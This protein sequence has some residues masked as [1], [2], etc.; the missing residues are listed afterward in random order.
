MRRTWRN[1]LGVVGKALDSQ[2]AV[3][4]FL[5]PGLILCLGN[6]GSLSYV[7]SPSHKTPEMRSA[8]FVS[9][10]PDPRTNS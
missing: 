10:H 4:S 7:E 8:P 6:S 2:K 3:M 1:E 9:T 5:N